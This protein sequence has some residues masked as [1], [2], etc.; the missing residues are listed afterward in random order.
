MPLSADDHEAI[1]QLLARYN[2]AVDFGET[3]AWAACF[4]AD[5]VFLCTGLPDG[6]P[7]GGRHQ[8]PAELAAYARTHYETNSGTARHWN[9]NLVID[10]DGNAATMKCYLAAQSGTGVN[11]VLRSIGVYRDKLRKVD[12]NW[13]FEERHVTIG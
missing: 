12:G 10:G 1:R 11:A 9:W 8:G 3:D 5:G 6:H 2:F 13:L 7:L 4:V